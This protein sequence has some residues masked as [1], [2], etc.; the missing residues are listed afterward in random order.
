MSSSP[1]FAGLNRDVFDTANP[2]PYVKGVKRGLSED[3]VRQISADKDEPMWM[4]EHRL[5]SLRTFYEKPMPTWGPDLSALDLDN[6]IYYVRTGAEETD[7]W[8]EVPQE[9]RQVYDRLGIPEAE[10]KVL[11]GV[12]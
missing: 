10:R 5:A 4:L 8:E 3:L 12:G 11:A 9:I 2:A 1:I 6:I 7:N